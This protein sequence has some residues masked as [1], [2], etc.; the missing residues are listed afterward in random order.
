MK[1]KTLIEK[2]LQKKTNSEL[3][4]TI[5]LA[6]KNPEWQ[7]VAGILS[8]PRRKRLDLNIKDLDTRAVEGKTL[9]VPGKILSLGEI[10][11]KFKIAALSFSKKAHEKL[12]NAKC[13]ASTILEEIKKNPKAKDIEVLTQ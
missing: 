5:I 3:V 8:G 6:K 13:D 1:S 12:L 10:H 9:I 7:R 4:E 2:H 11:K